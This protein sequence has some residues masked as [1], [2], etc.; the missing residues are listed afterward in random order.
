MRR[1]CSNQRRRPDSLHQFERRDADPTLL[2]LE[3]LC[4]GVM[5]TY[6]S[7]IT[8]GSRGRTLTI[9]PRGRCSRANSPLDTNVL[10]SAFLNPIGAPA[11]V[12]LRRLSALSTYGPRFL[13]SIPPRGAR[14][15]AGLI[16][17]P[18]AVQFAGRA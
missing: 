4:P 12:R 9:L 17:S 8:A 18:F 14:D 7:T 10:V 5:A 16:T 11:Q 3:E 15:V 1:E 6:F 13:R 2:R